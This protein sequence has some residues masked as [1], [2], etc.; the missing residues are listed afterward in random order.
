VT[1]A[2]VARRPRLSRSAVLLAALII[3]VAGLAAATGVLSVR[4]RSS[5]AAQDARTASLAAA[6]QKVPALLSYSYQTFRADLARAEADTS[7]GFRATYRKLMS[8]QVEPAAMASHVVTQV[9]VSGVSV[10]SAG[11]GSA[12][13]LLFL[14][15]QTKTDARQEP[16]LND[17]AVRVTMREVNGTWLVTGL[18]PRS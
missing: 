4:L 2:A 1:A 12:T 8:G 3:V 13:L 9:T 16:V 15:E 10:I 6:R 5:Q 11:P 18:V 14:S 17:T 7:G